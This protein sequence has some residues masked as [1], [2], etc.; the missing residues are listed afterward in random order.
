MPVAH[1]G[2]EKVAPLKRTAI[3]FLIAREDVLMPGRDV[4]FAGAQPIWVVTPN[5]TL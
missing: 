1:L 5:A 4:V 2:H 3:A